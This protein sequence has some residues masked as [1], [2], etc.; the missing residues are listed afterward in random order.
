MT[1]DPTTLTAF[2][3][4]L[5]TVFA[6]T[7][8]LILAPFISAW[9]YANS[10]WKKA[11]VQI[12][13]DG[14]EATVT[15]TIL[16]DDSRKVV[17][18]GGLV[19]LSSVAVTI[20]FFWAIQNIF[21]SDFSNKLDFLS[22]NQTWLPLF[23]FF[24]GGL[25]GWIDDYM[26]VMERMDRK[27]GGLS[28][29][30]RLVAVALLGAGGA[31]WFYTKL[32][33]SSIYIPFY[34]DYSLG[35][36]FI[37]FFII[38]MIGTYSGSVIDGIDGLSGGVFSAIL[39]AYGTI[40]FAQNQIDLASFC[41][42]LVGG[43][44]AFLWFN[45]PPARFYLSE[46]GTTALTITLTVIAFLTKQVV[47]LPLIALPLFIAPL[48]NI[49]QIISKKFRGKKVFLVA[50]VH[51]H[52]EAIGWPSYRVTMRYWIFSI[53]CAIFGMCIALLG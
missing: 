16:H 25:V 4:F 51:H 17:R 34:G 11:T 15:K 49:I 10:M 7:S 28:L 40:A 31:W 50:P 37:P 47:L 5:P 12:G 32:D 26:T 39:A 27:A 45:V 19:I 3:V 24:V 42:V 2:K 46:T 8:G 6:F 20:L 1:F 41:F 29:T 14:K 38:A 30:K 44:L 9:L 18:M 33:V 53:I 23:T 13:M 36:W 52:F 48:S 21:P 35:L 43:T 22:R